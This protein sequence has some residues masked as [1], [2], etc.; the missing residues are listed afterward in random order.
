MIALIM[1]ALPWVISL[2]TIYQVILTG[3]LNRWCWL[4]GIANQGLWMLF[5]IVNE[6]WGLLPLNLT[7][8]I[9]CVRNHILWD[10]NKN[11]LY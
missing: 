10:R 5:I 6:Q 7:M 8:W 3:N 9:I 2:S 1:G 11:K 4:H